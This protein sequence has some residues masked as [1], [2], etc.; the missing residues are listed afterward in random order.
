MITA[1]D[2]DG[3]TLTY[4]A[5]NLPTGATFNNQTFLWTPDNDQAGIYL[6]TFTADDGLAQATTT[7][8]ITVTN[9]NRP[10]AL[11]PLDNKTTNENQQLTFTVNATD[12]D[13]DNVTI[14]A[15]NLP[16]GATFANRQFIWTPDNNQSGVYTIG[17]TADD[18]L[19]QSS[20]TTQIT[21]NETAQITH[22]TITG[23]D[24]LDTN[25]TQQ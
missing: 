17:F 3:D 23:P 2:P 13:N 12:P 14:T 15:D 10:P 18:G 6:I 20:T 9:T 4:S 11:T 22:I 25:T 16:E 8:Q 19:A 1:Y 24:C 5:T 7:T 21:V